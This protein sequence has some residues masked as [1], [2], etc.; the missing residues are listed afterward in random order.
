MSVE[1]AVV[2]EVVQDAFLHP[3]IMDRLLR[4]LIPYKPDRLG[5]I[6]RGRFFVAIWQLL[7]S[8]KLHH[9]EKM[10]SGG[11]LEYR[12]QNASRVR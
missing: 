10:E 8:V 12:R 11:M 9:A 2:L 7:V 3:S 1:L 5:R 6:Q 4:R